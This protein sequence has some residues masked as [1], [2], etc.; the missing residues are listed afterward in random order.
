MKR[1]FTSSPQPLKWSLLHLM[2]PQFL[3]ADHQCESKGDECI[4]IGT[5]EVDK[6]ESV[7]IAKAVE[8]DKSVEAE[9]VIESAEFEQMESA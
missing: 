4:C 2:C 6:K 3:T 7:E 9:Q 5:D 8:E 1:Q